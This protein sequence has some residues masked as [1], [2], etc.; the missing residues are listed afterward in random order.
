MGNL[1]FFLWLSN[2]PLYMYYIF[3]HSFV[4]GPLGCFHALA[5]VNNAALNI[6]VHVPFWIRVFIFWGYMLRSWISGSYGNSVFSSFRT[7][8]LFSIVAAPTYMPAAAAAKSLQSCPTVQ[9]HRRH[10]TR[11]LCAQ[12]SLNKNT[13]VGCH[14]F[15]Q[16]Y[17]STNSVGGVPFPPHPLQ[18][19]LLVDFLITAILTSVRSYLIVFL[20]YISLIIIPPEFLNIF[21]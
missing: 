17:M 21:L 8:I 16:T 3:M 10:P 11:L 12:D 5:I 13:G 20:I 4:N 18:H 7:S 19:L 15:L 6:G 2:I 1:S 9:P 14:F